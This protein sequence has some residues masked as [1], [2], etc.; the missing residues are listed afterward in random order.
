MFFNMFGPVYEIVKETDGE[1]KRMRE[2]YGSCL[3]WENSL[4]TVTICKC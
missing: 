1:R 2:T 3:F 4:R